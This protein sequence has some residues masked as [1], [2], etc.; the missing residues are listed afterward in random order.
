[1]YSYWF[2]R[3]VLWSWLERLLLA[4]R[5]ALC[6]QY[7][8]L[9]KEKGAVSAAPWIRELPGPSPSPSLGSR[10]WGCSME[11]SDRWKPQMHTNPQWHRGSQ[12]SREAGSGATGCGKGRRQ[13]FP[14]PKKKLVKAI[15]FQYHGALPRI[16]RWQFSVS[17]TLPSPS[18]FS[19]LI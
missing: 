6:S 4:S 5:W 12:R 18:S 14:P 8:K 9:V 11:G 16:T 15:T 3:H 2:Y 17:T 7:R 13:W 1:M 10:G 19:S